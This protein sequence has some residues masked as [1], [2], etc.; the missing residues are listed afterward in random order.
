MTLLHNQF[1]EPNSTSLHTLCM[2]KQGVAKLDAVAALS[3]KRIRECREVKKW[4]QEELA[5][6]TGWTASRPS[7]AQRTALSPSRIANFEQGARRVGLEEAQI[8]ASAL[9]RPAPYFMGVIS[10][11]ESAVLAALRNGLDNP[12]ELPTPNVAMQ[13]KRA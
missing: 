2:A 12:F 3:G 7:R 10:E 6:A 5:K 4:T 8:L 13:A 9:E 11:R 1:S